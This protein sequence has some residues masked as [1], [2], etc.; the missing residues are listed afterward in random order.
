LPPRTSFDRKPESPSAV[1]HLP[2]QPGHVGRGEEPPR[3][4]RRTARVA[5]STNSLND[6]PAAV[7]DLAEVV[8]RDEAGV[9]EPLREARLRAEALREV[10]VADELP[11]HDLERA[12]RAEAHVDGAVDGAHATFTSTATSRPA[13]W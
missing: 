4:L 3:R 8:E 1:G 7:R 6:V 2:D 11:P 12:R 9:A 13:T 10:G 5:P